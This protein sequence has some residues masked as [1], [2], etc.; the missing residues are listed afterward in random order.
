MYTGRTAWTHSM[1]SVAHASLRPMHTGCDV[2]TYD[3][4][5]RVETVRVWRVFGG[6]I[7]CMWHML[8]AHQGDVAC[9]WPG[10]TPPQRHQEPAA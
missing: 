5:L 7:A 3:T 9:R 2:S 10:H 6:A 1:D 8:N 4:C